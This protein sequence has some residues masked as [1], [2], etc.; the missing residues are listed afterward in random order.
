[1]GHESVY[2][3]LM[4]TREKDELSPGPTLYLNSELKFLKTK[5]SLLINLANRLREQDESL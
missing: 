3:E 4:R 2:N 1:M 5:K